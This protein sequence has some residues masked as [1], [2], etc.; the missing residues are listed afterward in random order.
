MP[1]A[2]KIAPTPAPMLTPII[3]PIDSS[4][5]ELPARGV[6]VMDAEAEAEADADADV[7]DSL[8]AFGAS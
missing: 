6:L 3:P 8:D 7:V 2:S 1:T 5:L 4:A